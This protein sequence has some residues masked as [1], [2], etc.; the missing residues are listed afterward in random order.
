MKAWTRTFKSYGARF[1]VTHG[2][3]VLVPAAELTDQH[4]GLG[5]FGAAGD[6]YDWLYI[7]RVTHDPEGQVNITYLD[8][9]TTRSESTEGDSTTKTVEV[10]MREYLV[11]VDPDDDILVSTSPVPRPKGWRT[12]VVTTRVLAEK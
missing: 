1:L 2:L 9:F 6:D 11:T 12:T 4:V 10:R 7:V 8:G 3:G 5:L